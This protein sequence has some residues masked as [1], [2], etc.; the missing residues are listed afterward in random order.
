[1]RQLATFWGFLVENDVWDDQLLSDI[2]LKPQEFPQ[3]YRRSLVFGKVH[4]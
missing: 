4:E 2:R 1:M 3:A